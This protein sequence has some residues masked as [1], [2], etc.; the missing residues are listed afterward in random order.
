MA[1]AV[2]GAIAPAL[3]AKAAAP[4]TR[5]IQNSLAPTDVLSNVPEGARKFFTEQAGNAQQLARMK[6]DMQAIGPNAVLADVSPEMQMLTRGAP[7]RPNS[8]GP[9][10]DALTARDMDKNQRLAAALNNTIGPVKE[11]S[12]IRATI[13]EG[14][15]ALSPQYEKALLNAKAVDNSAVALAIDSRIVDARGEIRSALEKARN[16]LNVYGTKHLDPSPRAALET[17]HELDRL[18]IK[19][20]EKGETQIVQALAPVRKS[21]DAELTRVVPGIKDVDAQFAELAKQGKGLSDGSKALRSGPDAA[22]PADLKN[23]IAEQSQGVIGPSA[24]PFRM[25]QGARAEID[26]ISNATRVIM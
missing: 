10:V 20:T 9:I 8:H 12:A 22:R 25:S 15:D 5:R 11:P 2:G 26:R 13:K 19:A 7:S 16:M 14:Q 23:Q 4:I 6:A 1:G 18:L 3:T 17:R 21:I 24:V